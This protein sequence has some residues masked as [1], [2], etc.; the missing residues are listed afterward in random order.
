MDSRIQKIIKTLGETYPDP[1][2]SLDFKTPFELLVAAVLSAQCTD[3]RV[4]KVTPALFKVADTPE[5]LLKLGIV[6]LEKYIRSTGFFHAKAKS[7]I[8]ASAELVQK[9]NGALPTSLEALQTLPGIGRK[10]ASVILAQAFHI[11]AFPVDRHV[12][13]VANRLNLTGRQEKTPEKVDLAVRKTVPE[14]Y[15]INLH[16]QL[17]FLGRQICRPKPKCDVCPLLPYCPTGQNI[18]Q[19]T[20]GGPK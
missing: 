5:G 7:L 18:H 14:K 13:R 15:W 8:G 19:A 9:Y 6:K 4:N 12:F 3:E 11:P 10:T 16:M 1:K 17:V 20:S 2:P